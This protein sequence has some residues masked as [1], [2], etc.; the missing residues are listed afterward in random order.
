MKNNFLKYWY[1]LFDKQ[2]Y[3]N[4]KNTRRTELTIKLF[5][6]KY[7]EQINQ[8]QKKIKDQKKISFLHSGHIG[9]IINT[10]PVIKEIAKTHVCELY[11]NIDKPL[12][13]YHHAHQAGNVFINKKIYAPH[14]YQCT[15]KIRCLL[16]Q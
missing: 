5:K 11:I 1:K 13:I 16:K 7:E 12:E 4:F 14:F 6:S 2:A 3:L 10:L 9:D 8:I 15:Q